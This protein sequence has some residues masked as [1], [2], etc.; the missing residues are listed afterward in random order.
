MIFYYNNI[1]SIIMK[2][3]KKVYEIQRHSF[4]FHLEF[5]RTYVRL[6]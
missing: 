3:G 2:I 5:F 1:I 4:F 6:R